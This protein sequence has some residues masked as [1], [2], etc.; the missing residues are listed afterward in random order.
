MVLFLYGAAVISHARKAAAR[1]ERLKRG[2]DLEVGV[3]L[4]VPKQ[5]V[6]LGIERL[7]QVVFKQQRLGLRTHHG[8]FHAD[9][10]AHHVAD[11]RTAMVFLKVAADPFFQVDGFAHVQ[12]HAVRVKVAVNAGQRRQAGHLAEQLCGVGRVRRLWGRFG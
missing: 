9:N 1:V 8:G 6:V 5:N 10:F 4:V 3:A 7:D 11:A 2:G 12:H